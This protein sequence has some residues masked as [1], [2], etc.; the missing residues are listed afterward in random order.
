MKTCYY[1][2]KTKRRTGRKK[3]VFFWDIKDFLGTLDIAEGLERSIEEQEME[4]DVKR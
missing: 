1:F 4:K 2:W 3:Y